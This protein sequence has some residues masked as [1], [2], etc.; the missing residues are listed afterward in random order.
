MAGAAGGTRT[1]NL[2]ENPILSRAR[3]PISPLRPLAAAVVTIL[4]GLSGWDR[5]ST[6]LQ[7]Q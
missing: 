4:V 1:L 2:E 3:L 7:L 5:F 6:G